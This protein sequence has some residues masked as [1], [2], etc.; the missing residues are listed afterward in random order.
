MSFKLEYFLLDI[1][2]PNKNIMFKPRAQQTSI[3]VAKLTPLKTIDPFFMAYKL[4]PEL[5]RR[6]IPQTDFGVHRRRSYY[7]LRINRDYVGDGPEMPFYVFSVLLIRRPI[8][9]HTHFFVSQD[10]VESYGG[11]TAAR[12]QIFRSGRPIRISEH[13]LQLRH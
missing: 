10:I 2:I 12:I 1:C 5:M 7:L 4:L 11:I 13:N 8:G 9:N 3:L 6:E